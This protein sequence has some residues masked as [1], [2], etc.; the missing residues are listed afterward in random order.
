MVSDSVESSAIKKQ[1]EAA[2]EAQ[3]IPT[4]QEFGS[5]HPRRPHSINETG[6]SQQFL[7]ELVAKHLYD[8][9]VMSV[10]RLAQRCKLSGLVLQEILTFLRH[11]CRIEVRAGLD[12]R[13]RDL[14]Y[15]LTD[16][17]KAYA[18]DAFSKS[19][20]VGPAPIPLE[21]YRTIVQAQQV[22][23]A[24]VTRQQIRETFNDVIIDETLLNQ[25]GPA[26]NA[27]RPMLIYGPP[28]T[29]KTYISRLLATLFSDSVLI[30]YALAVGDTVIEI[31]DPLLHR[32]LDDAD[33]D[34]LLMDRGHD[35]RLARC[36]RPTVITGGE[37]TLDM[38]DV[39]RNS[40]TRE[41]FAPLQLKANNGIFII[42]DLGR[43]RM[44]VE[45]LFNRWI[46]PMQEHKD[47]LTLGAGRHFEVPFDVVLIFSTNVNPL[48]L[49]D[50]AF[51]RR[52][53]HKIRF[54]YLTQST[55]GAIW[56]QECARL[57]IDFDESLL[58]YAVHQLHA[59]QR[60]PLLPCHPRDLLELALDQSRFLGNGIQV[61]KA[62][63]DWAWQSHFVQLDGGQNF[64]GSA[65]V[66]D[67]E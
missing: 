51:L 23:D 3:L 21:L 27:G 1:P 34:T 16:S 56:R 15:L 17:G 20:Y 49:A 7:A 48:E 32:L 67:G 47:Y 38:L 64:D 31:F 10:S 14:R 44:N 65:A 19:G 12:G 63:L 50:E 24:T 30:P 58:N 52:M 22:H 36:R 59:Q 61:D 66:L 40:T 26:M 54:Q 46:I 42:D 13:D 18:I 25:L 5:R 39:Y 45:S 2:A 57:G 28:G 53:G 60:I 9:G 43:Q 29:G 6:L 11:E 35:A 62:E 55:Y 33:N 4:L 8:G 41:Y 37:L